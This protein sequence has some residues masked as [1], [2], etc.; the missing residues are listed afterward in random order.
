MD[1]HRI[2][3]QIA[4]YRDLE[5]VPTVKDAIAQAAYPE[6][7]SFGICWQYADSELYYI[8]LLKEIPHCRV[9]SIPAKQSQGLGQAWGCHYR[10][11]QQICQ[12]EDS[13][14]LLE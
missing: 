9:E 7:L 10:I 12:L 13:N 5:L 2:F 8:D 14:T 6:R 3:I 4:A 11:S 1:N